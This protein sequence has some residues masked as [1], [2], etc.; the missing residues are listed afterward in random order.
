MG[1]HAER[2]QSSLTVIFKLVTSG[3]TSI[4]LIVL[5][6][7]NLQFQGSFV[8][9]SL[10]SIL[11]I[12]AA[13]GYSLLI[14]L[15]SPPGVLVFIRLLTGYGSEYYLC[16]VLCCAEVSHSVVSYSLPPHGL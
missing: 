13:H 12:V 15:T 3:L 2:A 5:G 8:S 1:L 16:A 9:I 4:I 14:M 7:V 6:T 11:R 10:R